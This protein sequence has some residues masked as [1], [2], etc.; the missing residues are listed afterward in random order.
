MSDIVVMDTAQPSD[1]LKSLAIEI[2]LDI[3]GTVI[4]LPAHEYLRSLAIKDNVTEKGK[5]AAGWTGTME[6]YAPIGAPLEPLLLS[7]N[8]N[9]GIAIRWSWNDYGGDVLSKAPLYQAAIVKY[10]PKYDRNGVSITFDL[11]HK[12]L[13]SSLFWSARSGIKRSWRANSNPSRIVKFIAEK[14]LKVEHEIQEAR[15]L[16]PV[17]VVMPH[18][19][20]YI[21]FI[22][23]ELLPKASSKENNGEA[24]QFYFDKLNVLHFHQPSYKQAQ[25]RLIKI[26]G[27]DSHSAGEVISFA[28]SEDMFDTYFRGGLADD[29]EAVSSLL[30]LEGDVSYIVENEIKTAQIYNQSIRSFYLGTRSQIELE[31]LGEF[32]HNYLQERVVTA[33]LE[34]LGNHD[35]SRNDIV[36]VDKRNGDGSQHFYS[37]YYRVNA[38]EHA[39]TGGSW[40]TTLTLLR[41]SLVGDEGKPDG[42]AESKEWN[43]QI[44]KHGYTSYGSAYLD[45]WEQRKYY[46]DRNA[47]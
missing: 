8:K 23:K 42:Q 37:G 43:P 10:S 47:E 14:V 4:L 44:P 3:D 9:R 24:F 40:I 30:G 2:L 34:V 36:K 15:K 27:V 21:R 22:Q 20:N 18:W 13:M 41:V 7:A 19:D 45:Q 33:D 12:E 38:I 11:I 6:L 32:I 35:H 31:L 16:V 26:Y 1:S 17:P 39:I 28:V 25:N 5:Q 46:A 29:F